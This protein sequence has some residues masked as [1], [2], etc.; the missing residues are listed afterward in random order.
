MFVCFFL[1][2]VSCTKLGDCKP[3]YWSFMHEKVNNAYDFIFLKGLI[4]SFLWGEERAG[5]VMASKPP[6][7]L[8]II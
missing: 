4:F 2:K 3:G 6:A 7:M 1:S 8:Q 5:Y